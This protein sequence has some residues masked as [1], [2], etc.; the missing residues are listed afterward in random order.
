M[1]FKDLFTPLLY[2]DNS[3]LVKCVLQSR[4]RSGALPAA[5]IIDDVVNLPDIMRCVGKKKVNLLTAGFPCIG[6]S[7]IGSRGGLENEQSGLFFEMMNVVRALQPDMLMLENVAEVLTVNGG[8]DF[9]TILKA[10]ARERYDLRWSVLSCQE[11]GSPQLRRRWFCLCLKRGFTMKPLKLRVRHDLNVWALPMPPLVCDK[12]PQHSRRFSMLGNALV[13]M[14]ARLAFVRLL[15]GFKTCCISEITGEVVPSSLAKGVDSNGK[16]K[17]KHGSYTRGVI[18]AHTVRET[19]DAAKITVVL[20][21]TF[22]N[23]ERRYQANPSRSPLPVLT[24]QKQL[25]RFPTPRKMSPTHSY[26]LN[27]RTIRDLPTVAMFASRVNGV[28]QKKTNDGNGINP[29][30]VEWLMGFPR[31]HTEF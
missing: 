30:F 27:E 3:P 31:G 21:P 23:T 1:A 24:T 19:H 20:D 26:A 28:K 13:P 2:C 17:V 18:V 5:D 22:Y 25:T 9:E 6:F 4:F 29:E 15:S 11:A 8:A 14:V 7:T 12:Q 16:R 10:L